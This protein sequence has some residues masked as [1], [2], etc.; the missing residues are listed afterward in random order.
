MTDLDKEKQKLVARI[1]R[2]RRRQ[3]RGQNPIL[4]CL[5]QGPPSSRH[6]GIREVLQLSDAYMR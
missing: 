2:I 6:P 3:L 5:F 1:K 4:V